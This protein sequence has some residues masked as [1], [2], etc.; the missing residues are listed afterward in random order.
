MF[1]RH[2][3]INFDKSFCANFLM[4]LDF[5]ASNRKSF[6]KLFITIIKESFA[7]NFDTNWTC[8][9]ILHQFFVLKKITDIIIK[10]F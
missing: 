7:A 3:A 6:T 9:L 4:N 1:T 2:F 8:V 5:S 10:E